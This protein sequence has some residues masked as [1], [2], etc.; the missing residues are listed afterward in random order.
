M[1]KY[2]GKNGSFTLN[3]LATEASLHPQIILFILE[4]LAAIDIVKKVILATLFYLQVKKFHNSAKKFYRNLHV[5][6][7]T[8]VLHG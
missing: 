5:K 2:N 4:M 3:E 1:S 8:P 7:K 6:R